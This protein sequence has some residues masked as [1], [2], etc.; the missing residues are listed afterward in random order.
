MKS[1]T[2]LG[3]IGY[4]FLGYFA[5]NYFGEW[6][7]VSHTIAFPFEENIP[8]LEWAIIGYLFVF[9]SLLGTYL[10][11]P[12]GEG[13][14]KVGR[15]FFWMMTFHYVIFLIFPVKMIWR[16]EIAPDSLFSG[17]TW[18]FYAIDP[19]YNCFPS[20]HVAFPTLAT[21]VTWPEKKY[22]PLFI[23]LA[24]LTAIAV[25]LV[26]QHYILDAVAGALVAIGIHLY[27]KLTKT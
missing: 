13:F 9:G 3:L 26:K 14:T 17:L 20:M 25:V 5:T 19:L 22:R 15:E 4:F 12:S 24:G 27:F 21:L 8:F 7:G 11:I 6:R 18:A 1:K 23:A 16:P 2:A 10:L